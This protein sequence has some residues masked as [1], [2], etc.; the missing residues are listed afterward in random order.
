MA[1]A[2]VVKNQYGFYEVAEKPS[3]EALQKYYAEKYYQ[4]AQGSYEKD[5]SLAEKQYFRAKTEQ[6]YLAA[7]SHHTLPIDRPPRFLDVGCGEGWALAY[8]DEAGWSCVGLDYSDFGCKSQNPS[9]AQ[10]LKVGDIYANLAALTA[11][12]ERFDLILL[13]NVLEHVID[14]GALLISL[15]GLLSEKG[16]LIVEVP[17]DFSPLQQHLLDNG[18]IDAP[19]WVVV[20]D[21]LSYFGPEG[22][23]SLAEA[24]GWKVQ[25]MMTDYPIDL[26]LVNPD[27]NYIKKS[28]AGKA[29][30]LARVEI[31]NL[32]H[33]ISPEK[34]VAL[35]SALAQLGIG[36]ALTVVMTPT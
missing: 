27:T 22:L 6:K 23:T 26:S 34:A 18:H 13:D 15:K 30:H 11:T 4:S 7:K 31:E 14:P 9:V 32:I 17:N 12:N 3:P 21:H 19:F 25:C 29:C 28:T 33:S 5:Y 36:R 10:Y 35:Y 20:P 1:M 2:S 24:T 8:F 16:A